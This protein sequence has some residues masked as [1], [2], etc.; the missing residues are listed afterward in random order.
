MEEIELTFI[1]IDRDDLEKKLVKLGANIE[2][3]S[4][5]KV[6]EIVEKLGLKREDGKKFSTNQ[7]Y[8]LK[9]LSDLDENADNIQNELFRFLE[10]L[11]VNK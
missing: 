6:Y 8:R 3:P 9:G 10:S 4:W 11:G 5:D 7:T 2:G 1:D